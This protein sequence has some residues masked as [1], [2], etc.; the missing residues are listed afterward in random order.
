MPPSPIT[1]LHALREQDGKEVVL[2]GVYRLM[3]VGMRVSIPPKYKGNAAVELEGGRVLLEPVWAPEALRTQ[4]ELA[5]DGARVRVSGRFY[6]RAPESPTGAS[7]LLLPCLHP[8]Q[9][10]VAV[11]P[12]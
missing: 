5:L 10:V 3:D 2:E 7:N 4:E 12:P 1:Q 9:S 8:V 6:L 11:A